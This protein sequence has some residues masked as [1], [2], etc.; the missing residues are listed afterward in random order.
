MAQGRGS[1]SP[2]MLARDIAMAK[3]I[4]L[5]PENFIEQ[6]TVFTPSKDDI[7]DAEQ[8]IK[9]LST[10]GDGLSVADFVNA[11]IADPANK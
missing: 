11:M 5:N 9:H 10:S 7:E 4:L 8:I 1:I 3:G 6:G 2:D